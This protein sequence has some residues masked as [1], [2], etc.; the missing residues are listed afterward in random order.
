LTRWSPVVR[1]TLLALL[2]LGIAACG[3]G[4]DARSD[5]GI[6]NVLL[7]TIDTLRA[8][9]LG[10]YGYGPARTP[11]LDGLA[12]EGVRFEHARAHAPTTLPSHATLLCGTYAP[13]HGARANGLY[14][15]GPENRTLAEILGERGYQTA[16]VVASFV[17]DGRFGLAQGF[18]HYDDDASSMVK[19]TDFSDATRRAPAVNEAA[20]RRIE[21]F[22]DRPWF[23]WVHYFD[24]H[25]PYSPPPEF[26]KHFSADISGRYDAE[27]A[28]VD[29]YLGEL[30]DAL[31]ESGRGRDTLVVVTSD[32]GEGFPGP[33][34]ELTH[35]TYVYPDTLAV[36]LVF[37]APGVLAPRVDSTHVARHVDLVPT[38]LDLLGLEIPETQGR[39]LRPALFGEPQEDAPSYAESVLPWE[40]MGWSPLFSVRHSG[41]KLIEAPRPELYD[42]DADPEQLRNLYRSDHEEVS[43]LRD[44]LASI[45]GERHP[46]APGAAPGGGQL[47]EEDRR[48]LEAMGYG[49]VERT[50]IPLDLEGLKDPKDYIEVQE[51]LEYGRTNLFVGKEAEGVELLERALERDPSN[52][53]AN[54]QLATHFKKTGDLDRAL[55]HADRIVETRPDWASGNGVRGEILEKRAVAA[56]QGGRRREAEADFERAVESYAKAARLQPAE[57]AHS[58]RIGQ[59]LGVLARF[60]DAEAR[61][62]RA[63]ERFREALSIDPDDPHTN[64][65]YGLFLYR[66]SRYELALEP[67]EIASRQTSFAAS[68]RIENL[69]GL[70]HCLGVVRR[71]D[72]SIRVL[73]TL[74]R[75]FPDHPARS[76]WERILREIRNR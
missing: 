64:L 57:P 28:T 44:L 7:V 40:T 75:E 14:V 27:V 61:S 31:D 2:A 33:H 63:M 26:A 16:A 5:G 56:M 59:I 10:C 54:L 42:L 3:S 43:R 11:V 68:N 36:P 47:S 60:G 66:L 17:L 1:A 76:E 73:E 37:H 24:P 20:L 72:D 8:D 53:E 70:A 21:A 62:R 32:H 15:V 30:L 34:D 55:S 52:L 67:L 23:L 38:V 45:R 41:W 13:Y 25:A 50:E 22:D 6:E 29:H 35:G 18:D 9:R 51:W 39:S 12:A 58:A 46:D 48:R 71:F 4:S 69:Q 65:A 49:V 19:E 74:I